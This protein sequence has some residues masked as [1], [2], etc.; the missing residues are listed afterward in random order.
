MNKRYAVILA[1]L[2]AVVGAAALFAH[3]REQSAQPPHAALL[4]QPLLKGLK[5][6]EI[7]SIVIRA[8]KATLTL[9]KKNQA[10]TIAERNGFP[11]D[12][13]KVSDLVLKAI[14]L[15][16][17]RTESIG[18][19]DRAQ[20]KLL[21]PGKDGQAADGTATVLTFKA[22][23]G[24]KL[25]ELLIGSKY[26]KTEPASDSAHAPAD[27]RFVMLPQDTQQVFIVSDPL[28]LASAASADWIS[29][30]GIDIDRVKSLDV[31]PFSGE[32]YAIERSAESADWKLANAH[33]GRLDAGK[34]NPAI[35]DLGTLKIDDV[36]PN[37]QPGSDDFSHAALITATTFDGL[38][39]TLHVAPLE[40]GHYR[41]RVEVEGTPQ[42]AFQERKDE[43]PEARAA[44]EKAFAAEQLRFAQRVAREKALKDYVLL[45]AQSK[46]ADVL[47]KKSEMLEQKQ[48]TKKKT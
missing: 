44:R 24:R 26:F 19:K 33:G 35:Y 14:E 16:V 17:G 40:N 18:E 20:L 22:A 45:V 9:Q 6:S 5:A 7:A 30:D 27:G 3:K 48:K 31:K 47:K 38:R 10:W 32:G 15:K 25:A 1:L 42:R 37:G 11:A 46:L 13:N 39:Y 4:G 12:L 8:P 43:K 28:Q 36:A 23:D 29:R 2:A 41:L 21:A 34:A